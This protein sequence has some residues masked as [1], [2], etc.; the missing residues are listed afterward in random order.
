[1]RISR[2]T[3]EGASAYVFLAPWVLGLL[4]LTLGPMVASLALAFTRYDLFSAPQWTGLR[5]FE[6]LLSDDRYL[7][8]V[9]VTL[10]YVLVEVPL[11][12]SFALLLAIILDRG[13]RGVDLY[14]ALFYVP[15]LLG[16]SAA[17]AILWRQMFSRDGLVDV[18]LRDLGWQDAPAWLQDPRFALYTLVLLAVWQFGAPMVIFLAGIRQI[19]RDILEA[20][21]VDGAGSVTRFFRI[22][23]PLLSPLI[24]FNLILQMVAAFQMFTPAFLVSGGDGSPVDST[25]VYTLYLY[26]QAFGNL[27]MGYG[28]AMACILLV[29]VA[30]LSGLIF[31]SARYWVFY[32]E[33]Q[34]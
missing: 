16:G 7:H 5:N 18:I 13:I 20:A 10:T 31:L 3:R 27:H 32:M 22:T 21:E 26:N 33:G 19:P 15:S 6:L 23:L 11:Q 14:R 28:A 17:I 2:K 1:M 30:V 25:L 8:S 9:G 29:V 34:G 4:G 24:L 12:L